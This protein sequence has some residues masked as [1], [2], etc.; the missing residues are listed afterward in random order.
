M[1]IVAIMAMAGAMAGMEV[2]A[3]AGAAAVGAVGIGVG[4]PVSLL[5]SGP[6]LSRRLARID[7]IRLGLGELPYTVVRK[8][9]PEA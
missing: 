5:A 8:F 1:V 6:L 2:G 9:A 4:E 7:P 3:M